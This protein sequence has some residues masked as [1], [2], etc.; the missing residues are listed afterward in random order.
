MTGADAM[1]TAAAMKTATA[2]NR[3]WRGDDFPDWLQPMLVRELRQGIQSGAFV[4]TFLIL[5]LAL[6]ILAVITLLAASEHANAN[7]TRW[8]GGFYWAILGITV[9]LVIPLRGMTAI[10]AERVGNNLDLVRLTR[11]SATR[12]VV[13]KWLA[14]VAQAILV[15]VATLPYLVLQYFVG[16]VNVVGDLMRFSWLLLGSAFMAAIAVYASTRPQRERAGVM[17]IVGVVAWAW[18]TLSVRSSPMIAIFAIFSRSS[19]W[20]WMLIPILYIALVLEA[21]AASIAPLAENHALRKRLIGLVCAGVITAM[22]LCGSESSFAFTLIIFGLPL[23]VI[24]VEAL[25]ERP[26]RIRRMHTVFARGGI[27]GRVA[28]AVF[29]PGWATGFVFVALVGGLMAGAVLVQ[30]EAAGRLQAV[31]PFVT[32]SVAA[33]IFPLPLLLLFPR[34]EARGT[35]Y[36]IVQVLSLVPLLIETVLMDLPGSWR[37]WGSGSVG[38]VAAFPLAGLLRLLGDTSAGGQQTLFISGFLITAVVIAMIGRPWRREMRE[39]Q[40]LVGG[41]LTE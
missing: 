13:G 38:I 10:A 31:L 15:A 8:I 36:V 6:F 23:L 9:G 5:Q 34:L 16:G 14:N 2:D 11:L 40:R 1:T 33:I 24:G 21:A 25:L 22:G 29:T 35:F 27:A 32:L 37:S 18:V 4:W 26:V 17:G 39:T 7:M 12:I 3:P 28:A 30:A 41:G 19:G 20:L